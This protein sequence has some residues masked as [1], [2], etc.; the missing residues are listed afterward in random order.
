MVRAYIRFLLF[1]CFTGMFS[2]SCLVHAEEENKGP[3]VQYHS[4]SPAFVT[5]IGDP[6][7]KKLKFVKTDISLKVMSNEAISAIQSHD[8][9][10]RH[11]IVMMLNKQVDEEITVLDGQETLRLKMLE[12]VNAAL[13]EETGKNHIDDLLF[14]TFIVQR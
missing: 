12:Q 14:T 3:T 9:L 2:I 6:D 11:T 13:K 4:L 8:P 1:I 10:I 5:N 7:A